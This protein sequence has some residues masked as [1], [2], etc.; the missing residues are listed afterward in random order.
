M[1]PYF[2]SLLVQFSLQDNWREEN[3]STHLH[4]NVSTPENLKPAYQGQVASN[5]KEGSRS[6]LTLFLQEEMLVLKMHGVYLV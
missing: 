2:G 5:D 4:P 1:S 3:G 6:T